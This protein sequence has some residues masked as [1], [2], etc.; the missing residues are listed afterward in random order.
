ML[1]QDTYIFSFLFSPLSSVVPDV[2]RCKSRSVDHPAGVGKAGI[3]PACVLRSG[4]KHGWSGT[5][6]PADTGLFFAFSEPAHSTFTGSCRRY[7]VPRNVRKLTRKKWKL[8]NKSQF[9]NYRPQTKRLSFCP[10]RGGGLCTQWGV[11]PTP[12]PPNRSMSGPYASYWN[13]F[14]FRFFANCALSIYLT[15]RFFDNDDQFLAID[16]LAD[17]IPALEAPQPRKIKA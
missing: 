4:S 1:L 6:M 11:C 14:L 15:D 10:Q 8:Y 3:L 16:G 7:V 12:Q 9:F 5:K 13:A 17:S 2:S